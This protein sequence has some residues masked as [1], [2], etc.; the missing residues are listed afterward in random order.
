[1]RLLLLILFGT[2]FLAHGQSLDQRVF[3][4]Q[5]DFDQSDEMSLSW[6]LGET[7]TETVFLNDRVLTQGFQQSYFKVKEVTLPQ[8]EQLE[9]ELYPNPT[10]GILNLKIS[11]ELEE[12]QVEII[13]VGGQLIYRDDHHQLDTQLD[14]SRYSSGQYFIRISNANLQKFA[15]FDVIKL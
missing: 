7:F 9:A 15:V 11:N 2:P 5:G 6:T 4:A 12:Y 8:S 3:A 13:D 14:L 1:M 10:S